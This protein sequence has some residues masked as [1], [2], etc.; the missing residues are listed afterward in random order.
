MNTTS[1]TDLDG[2]YMDI[3]GFTEVFSG[4]LNLENLSGD[5]W[6]EITLDVGFPYNPAADGNLVIA[7]DENEPGYTSSTD[8][9][10]CDQAAGN[11]SREYHND[12]TNPDPTS[13]PT[14]TASNYY[15]NLAVEFGAVPSCPAP[16]AQIETNVTATSA[17]LA[18]TENGSATTWDIEWGPTGFTQGS[19]TTITGVTNP[20][21][22]NPPLS[23]ATTYDWYVRADCGGDQSTWTS[24]STFTTV[25]LNDDCSGATSLTVN[26]S[27][28]NTTSSNVGATDSGETPGCANYQGGDVWFS[29]VVPANGY[30]VVECTINGGFTDGGMAAWTGDCTGLTLHE[31]DD[32][33]GA[34]YMPLIEINSLALAGQTLYF[35]VWEYGN[36]EFGSFD[37]CA[38]TVAPSTT[39]AG[40][41]DN[42]WNTATNW[43]NGVPGATTDV[44]IPFTGITNFPTLSAAGSCNDITIESGASLLDNSNLTV[45]GTANVKRSF[46]ASEWQYISSPIAG[47]QASLFSGDYLQIW[48]EVNTQWE[49]VTV[50]TTA[51]TPVKGFSLWSTGTTT[52][53]GTL[54]TGNQGISVTNSGGDGFNLVGNPYP[55]FVDW[56]NLDDGPTA[57]WGAIYYWDETAYVSWNA[58]AGAGSQYVPPVQGFFI[59]TAST[60]T[61]SLTNADRTHLGAGTYYKSTN[62]ITNGVVLEASNGSYNDGLYVRFSNG[63]SE[64]FDLIYDAYK[65]LSNT[66]GI[67][68]LY[69]FTNDETILSIDV[70]PATEV[71]QLGFQNTANG[72]Y[73]IA[74][75]DIDGIS[76]VILED[77]KTNYM[78]NFEDGAYGFD[79][80]TTDDEKRFKLHLQTLGTNEIAEGLYNVYANDKVVYV[81]SEKVIN[82][83][84][85]K[86]YDIMGRIMVEV[87]VDNANFVKIPASF[88]TGIYVVVIEDGHNVSSNKVF[89]N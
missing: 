46:T 48:D 32:D 31:C 27:C 17:D 75:T 18:W 78:H 43:D 60:A 82:N 67:S 4:D 16:T 36:N 8:E 70:R 58:G 13:P 15:P 29:A 33:D 83:G 64:G 65:M 50:A 6:L 74:M 37:I 42:D 51:L 25:P 55:S 89:I 59:A 30:M 39:W 71:I 87:E 11:V 20:Y 47:A 54:N 76:S 28:S 2:G 80:L 9:F 40:T 7:V 56:S 68:Q 73:S 86:I 49:D 79:Y 45:N 52:F 44:T 38:H 53:S 85:V 57:T 19:G 12:N 63:A 41:T 35:N 61:F 24:G 1:N 77:T 14:G 3:S 84:T 72:T 81:N 10:Y 26:L 5:G 69:S 23:P 66:E 62:N 88:K 21:T 34:G 22:L